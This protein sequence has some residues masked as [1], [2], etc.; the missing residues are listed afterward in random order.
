MG[1]VYVITNKSMPNLAKVGF[2]TNHPTERAKELSNPGAPHPYIVAYAASVDNHRELEKS[3][4]W[5]LTDINLC[6]GKE[7]FKCT[8]E[9]AIAA[10]RICSERI[11]DEF[12]PKQR[13]AE[14]DA[15]EKKIK[16]GVEFLRNKQREEFEEDL[17][18]RCAEKEIEE[19]VSLIQFQKTNELKKIDGINSVL[20]PREVKDTHMILIWV[21]ICCILYT[22]LRISGWIKGEDSVLL[23]LFS[24]V[25]FGFLLTGLITAIYETFGKVTNYFRSKTKEYKELKQ[26][27]KFLSSRLLNIFPEMRPASAYCNDK[28]WQGKE[29]YFLTP[30]PKNKRQILSGRASVREGLF[31]GTIT[32]SNEDWVVT[33]LVLRV[34][35]DGYFPFSFRVPIFVFPSGEAKFELK[36]DRDKE[37]VEWEW[38][39][40]EAYGY[41]II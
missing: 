17:K 4:H 41:E 31:R 13:E 37:H 20:S 8:I 12:V 7:W 10:I 2:T 27:E 15:L 23:I 21:V 6:E 34:P 1:W 3:V 39:I 14:K 18:R 35:L 22:T 9:Q 28:K 40:G 26:K 19:I 32:N 29:P 36:I 25:F 11:H 33:Q 30:L 16:I 5:Y 38:R 24:I